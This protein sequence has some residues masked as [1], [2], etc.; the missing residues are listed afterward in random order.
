LV[1]PVSASLD[2]LQANLDHALPRSLWTI[3]ETLPDCVKGQRLT[4]KPLGINHARITP[5]I[6]CHITGAA[7][8]QGLTLAGKGETLII[9]MPVTASV[10]ARDARGRLKGK[11]ATAAALVTARVRLALMPDWRPKAE[12]DIDYVWTREPGVDILGARLSLTGKADPKLKALA[13][14]LERQIPAKLAR[15]DARSKLA[16]NWQ[17]AFTVVELNARNPAVWLRVAP[18]AVHVDPWRIEGRQI[19]LPLGVRVAAETIIGA[20]PQPPA[21]TPLPPPAPPISNGSGSSNVRLHL[22]V[23]ADYA[24]L[25]PVLARALG[26]LSRKG[27][28]LGEYGTVDVQFG[29]VSLYPTTNGRMAVGLEIAARSPQ[30]SLQ[31]RGMLWLAATPV[32]VPGSQKVGFTDL[33]LASRTDSRGFDLLVA[34]AEAPEV[35]EV[36]A[37]ALTQDF[38]GDVARLMARLEPK[39]ASLQIGNSFRLEARI[40]QFQNGRVQAL[41]QG[42]FM[43]V[44]ADLS[45]RLSYQPGSAAGRAPA[46]SA[47]GGPMRTAS[48]RP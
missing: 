38:S 31:P 45:A 40:E 10:N 26:R 39:L 19:T 12:V 7:E 18:E 47:S 36:I 43:P 23:L 9:T 22:P 24:V 29:K 15:L 2:T 44:S 17:Q 4:L 27:L 33:G 16:E 8:R 35:R 30:R 14:E 11:T 21:P 3:D 42:L 1:I 6:A 37:E 5:D 13:A 25:E 48:A 20:R 32:N 46:E 34:I 28:V 41:G